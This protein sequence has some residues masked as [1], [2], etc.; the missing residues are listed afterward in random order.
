M[1]NLDELCVSV[2]KNFSQVPVK[3]SD[4]TEHDSSRLGVAVFV[5]VANCCQNTP[6]TKESLDFSA[7]N[8]S[9]RNFIF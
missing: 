9:I 4:I 7:I 1:G 8:L 6:E 2:H 5:H 3:H